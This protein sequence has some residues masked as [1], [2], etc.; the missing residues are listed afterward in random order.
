[1]YL[2]M[3]YQ[4]TDFALMTRV[5]CRPATE[6]DPICVNAEMVDAFSRQYHRE[7][8]FTMPNR[9]ILID[10]ELNACTYIFLP[11]SF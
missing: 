6:G 11:V 3:R 1:M 2:N 5:N 8:G 10:G 4:K 9:A 7:F